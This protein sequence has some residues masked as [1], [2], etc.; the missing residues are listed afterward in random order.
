LAKLH[1]S[2]EGRPAY[3]TLKMLKI[4]IIQ[5]LYGH[6]DPEMETMLYG[7]LFYR[8]FVE[9]SAKPLSLTT[10]LFVVPVFTGTSFRKAFEGM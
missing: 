3:H 1:P 8:R 10:Q 7:N 9:L 6:S 2:M 5:Q 4:L